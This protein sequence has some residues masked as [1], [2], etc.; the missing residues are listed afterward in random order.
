MLADGMQTVELRKWRVRS[1]PDLTREAY[2]RIDAGAAETCGCEECFNFAAA[3]H[4]VYPPDVLELLEWLGID[5]LLEG[6]V[7]R[8]GCLEPGMHAYTVWFYLVGEIDSGPATVIAQSGGRTT[9]S[10]EDAGEGVGV[11]FCSDASGAPDA[12]GGLPVIQIAIGVSA[13]WVSNAP[14]PLDA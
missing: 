10:L 5:P 14:E 3:R 7:E 6:D 1:D 4:L 13:P 11:G 12:F 9:S 8:R 2:A